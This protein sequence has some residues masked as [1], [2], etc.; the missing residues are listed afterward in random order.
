MAGFAYTYEV[1]STLQ[2]WSRYTSY[3]SNFIFREV[4]LT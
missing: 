4:K 3:N 1:I 2:P